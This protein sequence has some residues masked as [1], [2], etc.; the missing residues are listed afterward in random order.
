MLP[1]YLLLSVFRQDLKVSDRRDYRNDEEGV[2]PGANIDKG[3]QPR[4][5]RRRLPRNPLSLSPATVRLLV[6]HPVKL[7]LCPFLLLAF[8]LEDGDVDATAVAIAA[9]AARRRW[10]ASAFPHDF[11][12]GWAGMG[13]FFR[14]VRSSNT[15]T[16]GRALVCAL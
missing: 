11:S 13:Y 6:V 10:Y 15:K 9:A 5:C 12:T 8:L 16:D 7:R 3:D 4:A 2:R 1:Q 14:V